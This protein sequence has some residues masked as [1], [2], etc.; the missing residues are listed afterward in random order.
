MSDPQ[1]SSDQKVQ[2]TPC[3]EC[4]MMVWPGEYHP[5]AACLMFKACSNAEQVNTNLEAVLE[6]GRLGVKKRLGLIREKADG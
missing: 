2:C 3:R 1:L 6:H 5:F 4:G